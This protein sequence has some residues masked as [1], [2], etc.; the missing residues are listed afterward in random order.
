VIVPGNPEFDVEME[1]LIHRR[2]RSVEH[3]PFTLPSAELSSPKQ[4]AT[5]MGG[6][7]VCRMCLRPGHVR[8]L[9]R[10]H[11][12]P[13]SWFRRQPIG[14]RMIRNAHANIVPLCRPCHSRIDN[15]ATAEE[16]IERV[17]ARRH[18][19]RS[20]TQQEITFAI[21]VRGRTWLDQNYPLM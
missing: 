17:E 1:D 20:L 2:R 8:P 14:L 12:V 10:H 18:L 19:R 9:T 5:K 13:E 3:R 4:T 21:Q 11:L 15:Y 16:R 6:E 7:A